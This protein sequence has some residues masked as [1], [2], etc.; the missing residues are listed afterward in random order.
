MDGPE[1]IRCTGAAGD[2]GRIHD[3]ALRRHHQHA[4]AKPL[5]PQR[6]GEPGDIARHHRLQRRIDA[7]S[8]GPPVFAQARVEPCDSVNGHA[9]K[10]SP[11]NA[12]T[13]NSRAPD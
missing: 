2:V 6:V 12:P 4:P 10:C 7:R 13:R 11:S 1:L 8:D 9:G 5:V 3:A